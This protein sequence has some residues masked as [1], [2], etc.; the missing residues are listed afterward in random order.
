MAFRRDEPLVQAVGSADGWILERL[1]HRLATELP[2]AMFSINQPDRGIGG[3]ITYYVNYALFEDPTS[4]IDVG[5]FTHLEDSHDFLGRARGM[6]WC[7]FMSKKYADW[8][9][10]L[11]VQHV[12]HIPMG[13]D[14]YRYRARLVLG[15]IGKLD[16]P[17]KGR[18]LVEQVRELPFADSP[19]FPCLGHARR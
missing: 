6:D 1:G 13:F 9:R 7:V 5:F 17:R 12:T 18:L 2:Y 10:E 19:F 14:V 15:V 11:G 3:G 8:L 4:F 16:H